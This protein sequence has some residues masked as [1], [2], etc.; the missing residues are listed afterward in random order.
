MAQLLLVLGE[1][2]DSLEMARFDEL[3][4]EVSWKKGVRRREARTSAHW[5]EV[6]ERLC[7]R[8]HRMLATS[9]GTSQ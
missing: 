4:Y 8:N 9:Y 7:E 1:R 6:R 3:F 2:M 5:A